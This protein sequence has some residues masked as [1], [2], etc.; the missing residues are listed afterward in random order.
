MLCW[1][2]V[3]TGTLSTRLGTLAPR[4]DQETAGLEAR[5]HLIL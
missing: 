2:L 4:H 5:I 1:S 3:R